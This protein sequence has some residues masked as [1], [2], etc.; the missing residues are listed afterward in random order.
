MGEQ[1]VTI[2][3]TTFRNWCN[4]QLRVSGRS[5][6]N[7]LTDL[8]DGVC[9]VALV[10]ALQ[11]R[12]IG[13]V[14]TKPTSKIQQLQ[15]ASLALKAI[16]DDNV[17]LV[18][19]G[20]DDIV[21][22]NV[23]IILGLV[24]SLV[25][26]YQ[27][28]G[29]KGKAP[30]RKLMTLWFRA[31]L[32]DLD[33]TNFTSDWNDGV[34]LHAL[35]DH[36]KP[37]TSPD[38][39]KLNRSNREENCRRAMV[40]AKEHL[41]VPRVIS[42]EDFANSALDELSAMTYLSYFVKHESAGYYHTLNWACRQLRTTNIT[43]LTTDWNNGYF[44]CAIV[45]SLGGEIPGWP[46]LDRSEAVENCQKGLDG[47]KALG[48]EPL[49]SAKEMADPNLDHLTLMA[50]LSRFQTIQPRKSKAERVQIRFNFDNIKAGTRAEFQLIKVDEGV[51]TGK[52]KVELTCEAGPVPCDITWATKIATCSFLPTVTGDHKLTVQYEETMI[53]GCP[54]EFLAK[55]DPSKIK[56]L[57]T[58]TSL[59]MGD[60]HEIKVDTSGSGRGEVI[61]ESTSPTGDLRYLTSVREGTLVTATCQPKE[62]GVWIV[63]VYFGEEEVEGSPLQL[64][65]YD[66][67]KAWLAGPEQGFVGD[68]VMYKG[69]PSR[70]TVED[71][72]QITVSGEG[73][74]R[75]TRGDDSSFSVNAS[76]V[77]GNITVKVKD[78]EGRDVE[79]TWRQENPDVY[80]FTY[81]PLT[82]G[83]YSVDVMWNGKPLPGS[84]F[85]PPVTD[86][87]RV[88]LMDDLTDRKDE[89]DHLA[90]DCGTETVLSFNTKDAG[91]GKFS[92][93]VLSPDGRLPV[94]IRE[95]DLGTVQVGFTAKVEGDHYIHLYWSS[96][97][98]DRSPILA[99]CPGPVLP[100]NHAHVILRGEG[101][102]TARST[103]PAEFMV[104]G[105]KAGP[106]IP[107][108]R[109]TGVRTDVDVEMRA[110]KYDRYKCKYAAPYPGGYLLHVEW[111]GFHIPGSPFKVNVTNKGHSDK[112]TVEGAG[113]RGG[114][115]GQELRAVVD[116]TA[117]GNGEVAVDCQGLRH[118]A[119]CDLID[120]RNGKYTLRM[121]PTEA[122]RHRLEVKYDT[123]H[124]PGSPFM[125]PIG[126]PPDPR[127]VRVYGP[128]VQSGVIQTFESKFIVETYGAGA[129]QLSVR[130]RGPRS[131]F[132]VDMR[133]DREEE[134]TI[135][136]R[137]DPEEPGE[138]HIMVRWSGVNVPGSPFDINI[139]ETMESLYKH[140]RETKQVE[141]IADYQWKEEI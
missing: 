65:V 76:G 124:V 110:M 27:I 2:Q 42:P 50:Y 128:G 23:K 106:G 52:V 43:N 86:R 41:N 138:Y 18:N 133:R 108:V 9:L 59:R 102:S 36:L 73:I 19:V 135:V 4:E 91:P 139:F 78:A 100:V 51:V 31:L 97:P 141:L 58:H 116:T 3:E 127:K 48:I 39:R 57:T 16:A 88:V 11:L 24:W 122:C 85:R 29:R 8:C 70:V 21:N 6:G 45:Q 140:V 121:F 22:G 67:Q 80:L 98:L 68:L 107:R 49:M 71:P 117:A 54:I 47:A 30:P 12:K 44:L 119:R 82:A 94:N 25:Q 15:N 28:A 62:V 104:D 75:A 109:M 77:G 136:C 74:L 72:S 40:L 115:V 56:L 87:S 93:E 125:I 33:I 112:V 123:E 69:S 7:L 89:N 92:A 66:P 81:R 17:K 96:V 99:Y 46:N 20:G 14:Y 5:I 114:Y 61:M 137:Y 118:T 95:Q 134:R 38:W 64:K 26:R 129:G 10:E 63:H 84:P 101:S 126:E 111:S 60:A 90:L 34:A 79:C 55:G 83:I 1:W 53:Q 103:V 37:G 131:A 130:V 13:K 132:K 105:K 120:H 32:P 35:L 113:L